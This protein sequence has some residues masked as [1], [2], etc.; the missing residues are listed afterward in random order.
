MANRRKPISIRHARPRKAKTACRLKR[1]DVNAL[2]AQQGVQPI[3]N[4]QELYADFWPEEE[5]V[6]DFLEARRRWAREGGPGVAWP[7]AYR[8]SHS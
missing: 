4:P 1:I 2:A 3:T 7:T 8:S 5:S 6:D